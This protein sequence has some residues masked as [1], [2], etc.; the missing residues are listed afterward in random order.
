MIENKEKGNA[1]F[2]AKKFKEAKKFYKKCLEYE[3]NKQY[4]SVIHNNLASVYFHLLNYKKSISHCT[5]AISLAP[6]YFL[7]IK[8]RALCYYQLADYK[9]AIHDFKAALLIRPNDAGTAFPSPSF[10]FPS[11]LFT[12]DI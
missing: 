7:P 6:S 12:L 10:F 1:L 4:L 11:I 8:R 2:Y 3:G 5:T 9:N